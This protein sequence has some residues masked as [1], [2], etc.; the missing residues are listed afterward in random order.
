MDFYT[1]RIIN[2]ISAT[3]DRYF[4]FGP[5]RVLILSVEDQSLRVLAYR[6]NFQIASEI[7]NLEPLL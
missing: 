1:L 4:F 5:G 2:E 7:W 3:F 6:N